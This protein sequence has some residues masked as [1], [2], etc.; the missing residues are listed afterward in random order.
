MA[1]YDQQVTSYSDTTPHIR[2]ISDIMQM[3]DPVDTPLIDVLGGL[4]AARSK[5]NI[6]QNGYKVE[7]LEDAHDPLTTAA[8]GAT[9]LTNDTTLTNWTVADASIFQDGHVI[10]MDDEYC[11]VKAVDT[12][13]DTITVY[14]RSYGGT[15][16]THATTE[17]IEIVGMARLEGD[18][19]DYGPIV[20]VTAPYN[21]TS[22]FQKALNISRTQM[23]ID[24]Y[25]KKADEFSYQAAK[26]I[27]ALL[28]LVNKSAYHGVR[29][30]GS[31]SAPRSMGG[32]GTFVGSNTVAA[33]GAI[34]KA[35]V[36]G[37]A[38]Q[39][40]ID[41]GNPD[42]LVMHPSIAN[43]LR[44]LLD[45]SSFVRV[46]QEE[47]GFGM[48]AIDNIKTQ[49]GQMR[50][51]VDRWCPSSTAYMLDSS[52]VGF[53]T[54]SPFAWKQLGLSGDGEKGEVVG[55]FSLLAANDLAHGT[56]TGITT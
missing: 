37:L 49:Y 5:F 28:R 15:N 18:D 25:A 39:I 6:G 48:R 11:V 8:A 19:A 1:V 47:H 34:A 7:I 45:S 36:D 23:V 38:E 31:A 22:I 20:D 52:K 21:Y 4:D 43:D 13:G 3:I 29:A 40:M 16:S 51:V 12:S 10:K 46:N 30:A 50:L 27:P 41:G 26:A 35:D 24:Q 9:G 14:S 33:G 44:D 2:V 55:E 42:I 53:Y 56:I 32:L 17:A 54:L